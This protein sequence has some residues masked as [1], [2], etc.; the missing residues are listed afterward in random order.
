MLTKPLLR[1][2][3]AIL[4]GLSV[5]LVGRDLMAAGGDSA[6]SGGLAAAASANPKQ[7]YVDQVNADEQRLQAN[8]ANPTAPPPYVMRTVD[9]SSYPQGIFEDTQAPLPAAEFR[10][11]NRYQAVAGTRI[12][13]VY[14]GSRTGDP[15]QG[16]FVIHVSDVGS[17]TGS[18]STIDAPRKDGWLHIDLVTGNTVEFSTSTGLH[19]TF[20]LATRT[21]TY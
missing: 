1:N 13:W 11:R 17:G 21:F 8:A 20:D 10:I 3:A 15:T 6:R 18:G 16:V 5:L 7:K 9:V 12:I 2:L 14:A 4:V 19:G